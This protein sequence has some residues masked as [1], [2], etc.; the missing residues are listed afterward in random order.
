VACL[1]ACP[2]ASRHLW[3]APYAPPDDPF[4]PPVPVDDLPPQSCLG[5]AN[6][7]WDAHHGWWSAGKRCY[8]CLAQGRTPRDPTVRGARGTVWQTMSMA[9]SSPKR[10]ASTVAS[11]ICSR[12]D[13]HTGRVTQIAVRKIA[14]QRVCSV[15]VGSKH[16]LRRV[17]R[18]NKEAARTTPR[19]P[20]IGAWTLSSRYDP[21]ACRQRPM[22]PAATMLLPEHGGHWTEG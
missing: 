19:R 4:P 21:M 1:L 22:F 9:V 11:T 12:V 8:S 7:L 10:F 17:P 3:V 2:P 6:F 18:D 13:H 14:K 20:E 15:I 16:R 5:H